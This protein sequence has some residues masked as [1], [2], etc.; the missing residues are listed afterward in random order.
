MKLPLAEV[1]SEGN[2]KTGAR[3]GM[4]TT[5]PRERVVRKVLVVED[6]SLVAMEI[7]AQLEEAGYQ[8]IGPASTSEKA[9]HLIVE[10]K[11]DV[12]LLDVNL[13]G[14]L[15]DEVATELTKRKI[16][17]AFATGYGRNGL[18]GAFGDTMILSKPFSR[19]RLLHVVKVLLAEA[20][21]PGHVELFGLPAWQ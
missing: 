15:S 21:D 5:A 8:V 14:H 11:P 1:A 2:L 20:D 19:D 17:F 13:E 18:P 9:K 10:A 4:D 3:R 16:P 12:A 6:E 7:E